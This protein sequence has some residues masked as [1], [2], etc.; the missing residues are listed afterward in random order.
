MFLVI[1][2]RDQTEPT[3]RHTGQHGREGE[4]NLHC[5]Y[6]GTQIPAGSHE[7]GFREG[8]EGKRKVRWCFLEVLPQILDPELYLGC[9]SRRLAVLRRVRWS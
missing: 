2:G 4:G 7:F 8:G 6:R 3:K 1:R 5:Y 9:V